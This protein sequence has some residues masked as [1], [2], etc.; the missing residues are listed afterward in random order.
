M[1]D[2]ISLNKNA[3]LWVSVVN[4]SKQNHFDYG[5]YGKLFALHGRGCFL[6]YQ[7][8]D[9]ITTESLTSLNTKRIT[10]SRRT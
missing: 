10:L 5:K 8:Q 1:L 2:K 3:E 7:I 9:F 6:R 4:I